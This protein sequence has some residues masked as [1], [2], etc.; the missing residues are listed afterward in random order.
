MGTATVTRDELI[1]TNYTSARCPRVSVKNFLSPMEVDLVR[2]PSS[3]V[4][5]QFVFVVLFIG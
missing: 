4:T 1:N 3:W 5:I 2:S